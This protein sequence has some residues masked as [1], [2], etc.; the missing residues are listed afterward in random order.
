[1]IVTMILGEANYSNIMRVTE[2]MAPRE[3]LA[4]AF[5]EGPCALQNQHE[6]IALSGA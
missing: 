5:Q 3:T 4:N 1:M 2:R 6:H